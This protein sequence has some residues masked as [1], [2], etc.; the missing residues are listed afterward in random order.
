MINPFISQLEEEISKEFPIPY[1]LETTQYALKLNK[2]LKD[3][4]LRV[5][6]KNYIERLTNAY[7]NIKK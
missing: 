4:L 6:N 1:V 2:E 3:D 5:E 7:I